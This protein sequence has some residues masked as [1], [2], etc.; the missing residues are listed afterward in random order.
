MYFLVRRPGKQIVCKWRMT[1]FLPSH[2]R[3][4]H[5]TTVSLALRRGVP[6]VSTTLKLALRPMGHQG[7]PSKM[8]KSSPRNNQLVAVKAT[9]SFRDQ[10]LT[11]QTRELSSSFVPCT[12]DK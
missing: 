1:R 5:H 7:L 9:S 10:Y 4:L 8:Q 11:R 6:I 2:R 3:M 12:P